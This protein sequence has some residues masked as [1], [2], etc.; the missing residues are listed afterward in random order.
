MQI[1]LNIPILLIRADAN[2]Q[3]GSG[4]VMRCI[5]LAQKWRIKNGQVFFIGNV[6]SNSLR[7]NIRKEGFELILIDTPW[8][9][10]KDITKVSSIVDTFSNNN[11]W[12]ILDG[13]HFTPQYQRAI[14]KLKCKTLII[15]DMAHHLS[16]HTDIL[17]NPNINA[18]KESYIN[19]ASSTCFLMGPQYALI[20]NEFIKKK[21]TEKISEQATNILVTMGGAD[22]ENITLIIIKALNNIIDKQLKIKV[23]IGHVN[24][25]QE[26]ITKEIKKSSNTIELLKNSTDMPSLMAWADIAITAGGV[27]CW[28]LAFSKT[29]FLTLILADNQKNNAY[30][31]SDVG[32]TINLGECQDFKLQTL[33]FYEN[34]QINILKLINSKQKRKHLIENAH[35]IVDGKG[36]ERIVEIML[37]FT[38]QLRTANYNDCH[39]VFIWANDSTTRKASFQSDKITWETHTKW[40]ASQL[41]SPQIMYYIAVNG[42]G[43]SIGQARFETTKNETVISISLDQKN[44]G[45]GL[46]IQ[47]IIQSCQ[48][49]LLKQKNST[50][51]AYIKSNNHASIKAFKKAGFLQN[52]LTDND[53]NSTITMLYNQ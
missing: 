15:D 26:H 40:F 11:I 48:K 41:K 46:S 13:Y 7:N 2:S 51:K 8:P 39:Q 23:I 5:A 22:P 17:L 14:Q 32:A 1:N 35:K 33:S 34:L 42:N 31:L 30:G 28:E 47:L 27:T 10:P 29:P 9:D 52:E 37:S 38:L 25:H 16:Y 3:I 36:T 50:I 20:R 6:Q 49:Y 53:K 19:C 21:Y 44:R 43:A 18:T 12:F 4:H 45:L 24:P